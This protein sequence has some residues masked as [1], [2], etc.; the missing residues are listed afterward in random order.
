MIP[1]IDV[2]FHSPHQKVQLALSLHL[3][4]RSSTLN[5]QYPLRP[6]VIKKSLLSFGSGVHKEIKG[7]AAWGLLACVRD[8]GESKI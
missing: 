2:I 8:T 6:C 7:R 3:C 5:I 1:F 4:I